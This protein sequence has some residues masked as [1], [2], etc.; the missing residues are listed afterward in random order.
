MTRPAGR[1]ADFARRLR[2]TGH[3]V[4]EA[5]LTVIRDFDPFPDPSGFDGV[6]FTSV[7][8]VERAPAATA[9]WPRVG[10]VGGATAEAL[11]ARG[12]PVGVVGSGSG[13]GAELA[14]AWGEARRQRLLLPQAAQAHAALADRLRSAG[15]EVVVAR[16]YETVSATEVDRAALEKAEL[17]CFHAPSAVRAYVALGIESESAFWGHGPTTR[18]AMREAG[19]AHT[20]DVPF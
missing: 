18:A 6:L 1:G 11:R 13:G 15:A 4:T 20:E 3:A 2:E 9:G 19:L 17:T 12:I 8:A 7:S 10:A 14:E 5:P 16:V